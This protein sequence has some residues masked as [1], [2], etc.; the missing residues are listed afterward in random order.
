MKTLSQVKVTAR[1]RDRRKFFLREWKTFLPK[2]SLDNTNTSAFLLKKLPFK[3]LETITTLFNKCAENGSF[4]KTAKHAK[5]IC[6]SKDGMFPSIDKLRPISLLSNIGKWFER[7]IHRRL[8]NWC[9]ENNILTDE[10]SGFTPGRRLQTRILSLVE[11]LRQTIA[12][13]NRPSLVIFVDFLSAFDRLWHP[14]LIHTLESMGLPSPLLKWIVN[15]IQDRSLC[16]KF[17]D[18]TSRNIPMLVGAPQGSVL[19]AT[20][21]R[22]HVHALP[23]YLRAF[24]THL[25]ADDL[26]IQINGDLE[27]RFSDNVATIETRATVALDRLEDFAADKL[28][29]VNVRKT[30]G[31]FVHGVVAPPYPKLRYKG[32]DIEFV[33]SFKYLGVTVSTKLG[34]TIFITDKIRKIRRIYAGLREINRSICTK[35]MRIRKK[36]FCAFAIPHFLWLLPLWFIF[37]EKQRNYIEHVYCSGLRTVYGIGKWEDETILALTREKSL[38]D[39]VFTYWSKLSRHLEISPDAV[40]FQQ[41]W[42]THKMLTTLEPSHKKLIGFCR[43]SRFLNRLQRNVQHSLNEWYLFEEAHRSQLNF[44]VVN[45]NTLCSFIYR[46]FLTTE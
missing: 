28:L 38:R 3:Y 40:V 30:K 6:L 2:K 15:W 19:A 25:F 14:S 10:Q 12:A 26:A 20:L 1:E 42:N 27:K 43:N 23:E 8:T 29:P 46:F 36:I 17:G 22:L 24:V 21:F 5:V 4:F 39:V 37:T 18:S 41:T 35:E 32:K 34:W 16:I 9:H 33:N 7:I 31:L 44:Y 13:N 45:S 11:D